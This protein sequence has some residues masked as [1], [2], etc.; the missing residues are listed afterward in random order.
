M[1]YILTLTRTVVT[2]EFKPIT[3]L[4][5]DVD[6]TLIKGL[7]PYFPFF[8]SKIPSIIL[9]TTGTGRAETSVHAQAFGHAV[10]KVFGSLESY[11]LQVQTPLQVIPGEKYHGCTD[12]LIALNFAQSAFKINS[13][14]AAPKLPEVYRGRV[15][16]HENPA[17]YCS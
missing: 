15:N 3:L 10:G 14:N 1:A 12:G 9:Y 2:L 8:S 7:I 4:T 11:E 17:M 6:G 5:F 13:V 16:R